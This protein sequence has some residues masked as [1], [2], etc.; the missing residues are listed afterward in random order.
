MS[1]DQALAAQ[2][3]PC[4]NF[5]GNQLIRRWGTRWTSDTWDK[6]S[7]M[8]LSQKFLENPSWGAKRRVDPT[9]Y[10]KLMDNNAAQSFQMLESF[11]ATKLILRGFKFKVAMTIGTSVVLKLAEQDLKLEKRAE[12]AHFADRFRVQINQRD[13]ADRFLLSPEINGCLGF[14]GFVARLDLNDLFDKAVNRGG[15]KNKWPFKDA[16]FQQ[17]DDVI[18]NGL[19]YMKKRANLNDQVI[20]FAGLG[21]EGIYG[22]S[23]NGLLTLLDNTGR[24][25]ENIDDF[26]PIKEIIEDVIGKIANH[27]S[28]WLSKVQS[29]EREL[30]RSFYKSA[31]KDLGP[32]FRSLTLYRT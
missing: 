14:L 4:K 22:S 9:P 10:D 19:F 25:L 21:L 28:L 11:T 5:D 18:F 6:D 27:H 20:E 32:T 7:L 15:G 12:L 29:N 1:K 3:I 17:K 23:W 31:T 24:G 8:G 13:N 16:L 26:I 2:G 30:N